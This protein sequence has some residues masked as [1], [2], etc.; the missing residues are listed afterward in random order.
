MHLLHMDRGRLF[1][2]TLL[3][4]LVSFSAASAATLKGR[5]TDLDGTPLAGVNVS[6]GINGP[7]A[8]TNERGEY[9]ISN[10][11][12]GWTRVRASLVGYLG[13]RSERIR[14][15]RTDTALD[16][17]L[18]EQPIEMNPTVISASAIG[19]EVRR[20]PNRVNIVSRT[21]IRR[22][23]ARNVQEVLQNVEGLYVARGEGLLV[24]FPQIIVRGMST[25]YLG[26]STAAL[27]M[28]NGHSINGSLGSW[29]NIGDLD[30]IPLELVQKTEVI[31]GPYA[32]TYG[33]GATGGVIN[34]LTRKHFDRP[35]GGSVQVKAGP[36][37]YRSV[38]PIVFGQ[39]ERLSYAAWGEFLH[40]GERETR[41]RST[42]DDNAFGYMAKG[43]TE[44]S[45]YGFLLGY[46]LTSHDRIDIL[47]NRIEKLNNY[48]GRPISFEE[49]NG[50]L[51]HVTFTRQ[52]DDDHKI[53][54]LGDYLRAEYFGPVDASPAHPDS[55]DRLTKMQ[56]WPNRELGMKIMFAGRARG[57]H[58]YSAGVEW[59]RNTNERTTWFGNR[60]VLEFDVN[61]TQDVYSIFLEDKLH[62]GAVEVTPGI[63]VEQWK[64]NALYSRQEDLDGDEFGQVH[65]GYN[66]GRDTREAVNAKLGLSW[67]ATDSFKLRASAGSTFRAPRITETYSP[68]YQTL[69]FLQYRSNLNLEEERIIS[70][71]AGFDYG[72]IDRRRSLSLTAFYV[73]ARDRI[74]FTFLGGFTNDDPFIIEHKNFDQ[75][76][77]GVEGEAGLKLHDRLAVG[78]NFSVV[79]PEYVSGAFDGNTPPGV[80]D[81]MVN[82]HLDWQL[83][84]D[85]SARLSAQRIGTIWDDN[86]NTVTRDDAGRVVSTTEL[87][88]YNLANLKVRYEF[89]FADAESAYLD[90]DITNLLDE[91]YD[92]Y[93]N[94]VWDYQPVGRALHVALGYRF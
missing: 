7:G 36:W 72:S 18:R 94:G 77:T 21:E 68:N 38:A 74:E 2:A 23:A 25:G 85:L 62:F 89:A 70:Y 56:Q 71:E 69:S 3:C 26:R 27:V 80:P 8:I 51:L 45:K 50:D 31:K 48:N 10:A 16:L 35:V 65:V 78:A 60:D 4:I 59:R 76:I 12:E 49:I 90:A 22:T 84:T 32:S 91:D 88:P 1:R 73:D 66:A 20:A 57:V 55:A 86:A 17:I 53:T 46:D 47:G 93:S 79:S 19:E 75:I 33:S 14:L 28:L 81:H 52:L 6:V 13:T 24:T 82:V 30:A 34:V 87:D 9:R 61:G 83:L 67:F 63:R 41:R 43:R 29:A 39:G 37:G 15:S 92:V 5:V 64:D 40:G 11:P 54:V 44:H 42:W 58:N